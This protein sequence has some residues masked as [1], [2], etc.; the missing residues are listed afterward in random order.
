MRA[1]NH[2][3]DP[4]V[5]VAK[6]ADLLL[7]THK[8]Q[9]ITFLTPDGDDKDLSPAFVKFNDAGTM[10]ATT[11]GAA[12]L[13]RLDRDGNP[14]LAHWRRDLIGLALGAAAK[15]SATRSPLQEE[16]NNPAGPEPAQVTCVPVITGE[17]PMGVLVLCTDTADTR[18]SREEMSFLKELQD[19]LMQLINRALVNDTAMLDTLTRLF[20]R[21]YFEQRLTQE[22]LRA[23]R[24]ELRLSLILIEVDQYDKIVR[25]GEHDIAELLLRELAAMMRS[26]CRSTDVLSRL[27]GARFSIILPDTPP[28]GAA[29]VAEK[30][31]LNTERHICESRRGPITVTCSIGAAIYP[32]HAQVPKDL[33]KVAQ[34]ALENAQKLGGNR[35]SILKLPK[36]DPKGEPEQRA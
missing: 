30:I 19:E 13:E 8:L 5:I 12:D 21:R 32:D 22:I 27:E 33:L 7:Q 11:V 29:V 17:H 26:S 18:I 25:G 1:I 34:S 28:E 24:Q 6:A 9:L 35:S 23:R 10:A 16:V 3:T 4:Q 14:L 15:S 31:R 20:N 36:A 2:V